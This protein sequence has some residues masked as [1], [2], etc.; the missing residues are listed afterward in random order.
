MRNWTQAMLKLA[1]VCLGNCEPA[2]PCP[3]CIYF[4]LDANSL[5]VIWCKMCIEGVPWF[6]A[7]T[8]C[9]GTR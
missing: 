2:C 9:E 6:E 4:V 8:G 7:M 3:P 1:G 5:D